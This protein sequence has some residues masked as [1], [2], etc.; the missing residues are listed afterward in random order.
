M[1][2][3][4]SDAHVGQKLLGEVQEL[5][6]ISL[7]M[8]LCV[9]ALLYFRMSIPSAENIGLWHVGYAIVKA[10]VLAKFIMLGRMLHIGERKR[11]QPLFY[12]SLYQ[13][14]ALSVLLIILLGLEEGVIALVKGHTF[15]DSADEA[16]RASVHLILAQGLVMFLL[17]LPY[18][19]F[20]QLNEALGA[21]N[22]KRLLFA[23]PPRQETS[24][25]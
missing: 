2:K 17:L 25:A 5:L 20:L 22:L 19:A 12:S 1:S 10:L 18:V 6:K 7:Y 24:S 9:S 16:L 21:G 13:T 4:R 23:I 11:R 8:L 14:L 3:A 15:R